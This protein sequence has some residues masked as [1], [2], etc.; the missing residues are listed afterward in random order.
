[1]RASSYPRERDLYQ[2]LLEKADRSIEEWAEAVEKIRDQKLYREDFG[3]FEEF[4]R[5][6]LGK[7]RSRVYEILQ[8]E[9]LKKELRADLSEISDKNTLENIVPETE[10][11]ARELAKTP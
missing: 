2:K 6:R 1:M 7:S 5:Q 11:H 10:S 3:T 9:E 4:C 8:A